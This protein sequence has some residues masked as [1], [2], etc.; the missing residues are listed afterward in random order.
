MGGASGRAALPGRLGCHEHQ[1]SAAERPHPQ[2]QPRRPARLPDRAGRDP[3]RVPAHEGAATTRSPACGRSTPPPARS[4]AWPT[5]RRW[6]CRA[7]R[8]CRPRSGPGANA[9]ASRR[10]ASSAY[11]TDRAMR[12][13]VFALAGR[14]VR[15]RPAHRDGPASCPRRRRSSTRVPIR[16]GAGSRTCPGGTLRLDRDRRHRATARWCG[17]SPSRSP[18]ASAEFV[19]AEEMGRMR[20]HW[21]APDGS[22]LLV[23]RVDETPVQRWHI[24]DPANPDRAARRDRL[25]GRRHPQRDGVAGAA[26]GSTAAAVD[27]DW[28]RGEF[29]YMVDRRVG[30]ARPAASSSSRATSATQRVLRVD[31]ATARRRLAAQRARPG[32]D[33]DRPGAARPDRSAATWCGSPRTRDRH[34]PHHRRRRSGHARRAAGPRRCSA[35]TATRSCSPPREEPTEIHL[36]SCG[37]SG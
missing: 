4:A 28:D 22:T 35:W 33:G 18:T 2:V 10:A 7:R 6:T 5:P 34:A 32:V 3:R 13:A 25:P 26:R 23:A 37:R 19:A 11:A 31:P 1:L 27:V 30:P 36:Y 17:P 15:R 16:P 9:P 8:T 21:W 29:P 14:P 20:G 24:A 12:Q